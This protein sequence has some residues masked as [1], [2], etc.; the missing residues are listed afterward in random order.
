MLR[1]SYMASMWLAYGQM[2][3][4][5]EHLN[6]LRETAEAHVMAWVAG[7]ENSAGSTARVACSKV[8]DKDRVEVEVALP[9]SSTTYPWRERVARFLYVLSQDRIEPLP[10][11]PSAA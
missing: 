8:L 1:E 10:P 2:G 3:S 5:P 11:L 6:R 7:Q 9:P 4:N